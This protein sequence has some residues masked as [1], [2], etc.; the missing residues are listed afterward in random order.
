MIHLTFTGVEDKKFRKALRSIHSG[1]WKKISRWKDKPEIPSLIID[2]SKRLRSTAGLA[3]LEESLIRLNYNM[4]C[5]RPH[6]L[7]EIY[8]HE[9][10]HI[11]VYA[12]HGPQVKFHGPEWQKI[13]ERLGLMPNSTHTIPQTSNILWTIDLV[14]W[15]ER[16]TILVESP[17]VHSEQDIRAF[18]Q[19]TFLQCLNEMSD[20]EIKTNLV[21]PAYVFDK[22]SPYF[23]QYGL[24]VIIPKECRLPMGALHDWD[25]LPF[26]KT[27]ELKE[28]IARVRELYRIRDLEIEDEIAIE[29]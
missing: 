15:E 13:M 9:L 8:G 5:N 21:D 7:A 22:M 6:D 3:F 24:R 29:G 26:S 28:A 20:L 25:K 14:G 4:L 23:Q 2:S 16:Y 19:N 18:A 12:I 17:P 11:L 27:P 1:Y 10:A